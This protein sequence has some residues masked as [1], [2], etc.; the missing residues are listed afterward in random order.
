MKYA[1]SLVLWTLGELGTFL[2]GM[3]T[4]SSLGTGMWPMAVFLLCAC[5]L[6]WWGSTKL[7]A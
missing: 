6:L 7:A 2:F 5:A 4:L 1:A 3:V